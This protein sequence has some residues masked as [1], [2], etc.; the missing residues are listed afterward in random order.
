LEARDNASGALISRKLPAEIM[1]GC[2]IRGSVMVRAE[3]I[4]SKP[5]PWNGIKFMLV[6]QCLGETIYPQAPVEAG[7]FD[8]RRAAFSTYVPADATNILLVM[9]LE[10]VT[11]KVWFDDVE[12]SVAKPPIAPTSRPVAGPVFKG[13]SLP[14]LRGA[15]V[16]PD[17]DAASLKVLGQDWNANL[18][19]FQL[20]RFGHAGQPS[21][22]E[23]Y[24]YWLEG[25]LE[26]L[27]TVLPLCEKYGIF[28]VVDLHSPPGGNA[29]VSGYVG[30]DAGLFKDRRAQAHFI[31]VWR[32][33][34]SR[35]KAAK[36]IW[37][38]DLA[39]EPVEEDSEGACDDWQALAEQTAK[40][41]RAIDAKRAIIVEPSP[42][43]GP[44]GLN[45]LAPIDI[46]NVVYSVHMYLPHAFT[47]QGVFQP[48]S[49]Y[50]Y[51]GLIEGK[52]WD[53]AQLEKALQPVVD[54]QNRYHVHIYIGEFSAI[55][56]APDNSACQYLSDLID[57]FEEHGWD[58]SYHAFREWSGWSIELGSDRQNTNRPNSLTNRQR[59]L[60]DWFARNQKP[61]F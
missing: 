21:G 23:T 17:I 43:G 5:H 12:F 31:E 29:T 6:I 24:D 53:K 22:L 35:Y 30:S 36:A 1:R 60:C 25:E 44:D 46:S 18:I 8:W 51:P 37:G 59:L 27:D 49:A 47:H 50:R 15:M 19:R 4:S 7:T 45:E 32:R 57:I 41:I 56:W 9:G 54:F 33:I 38:Y 52:Q 26:K 16:S 39:N 14:R 10:Q 2:R 34:A 28:V 58:W 40:A 42:W 48:G 11:G 20:I 61:G 3:Q 13:H 55:R